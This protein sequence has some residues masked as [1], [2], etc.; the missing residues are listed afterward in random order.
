M[1]DSDGMTPEDEAILEGIANGTIQGEHVLELTITM[2]PEDYARYLQ[3]PPGLKEQFRSEMEAKA[4]EGLPP[5]FLA[6]NE[7]LRVEV[8]IQPGDTNEE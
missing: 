3:E 5:G 6:A 2:S 1:D 4:L 7:R 8:N